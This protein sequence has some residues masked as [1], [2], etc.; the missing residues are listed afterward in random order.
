MNHRFFP[1]PCLALLLL[2][3]LPTHFGYAEGGL[4]QKSKKE[5]AK[6]ER[7]EEK[8]RERIR[9]SGIYSVSVWKYD[10]VFGRPDK[11]GT[12]LTSIRYNAAGNKVEEQTFNSTDGT[13]LSRINYRYDPDGNIVEEVKTK[14]NEKTKLVYRYD[15]T[16]NKK[17]IVSYRQDGTVDRKS[18]F[19]YDDNNNQIESRGY[20]SDG[21][22][23]SKDSFAYDSIGN[24]IEQKNSLTRFTYFYNSDGSMVEMIKS[25]RDF[26]ILDSLVYK[27]SDRLLFTYD[28]V[29]NMASLA[30]YKS[31]SSLKARSTYQYDSKGNV[32]QEADYSADGRVDYTVSYKY[33]KRQNVIE[34]SGIEKGRPFRN[35][36]KYDRR[37]NKR[38]WI[39]YD[40]V[41]EPKT[42]TKYIFEKYSTR[43]REAGAD[44]TSQPEFVQPDTADA[45]VMNED[46]FQFLGCRIIASD[47]TYLGLVWADT[48]HP[49]SIV[50]AWGQYGFE[51]SP[52]SIFNPNCPYGGLRGVFSPF[53]RSCPSPPSLYREGKFV[54]YLSDNTSFSPCVPASRLMT[55]LMQQAKAK[56]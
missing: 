41:N 10:Y 24:M 35:S 26:N 4:S 8:D 5:L 42:L 49:H 27:V 28:N 48:S 1:A 29:G 45:H 40:Q 3:F 56:E 14:G 12:Q 38:E 43:T 2:L 37:G 7:N 34:E 20:L 50:N 19:I 16:G 52:T 17:E 44:S 9:K 33:D 15:S 31:D 22:Q 55:F 51:G 6:Q 47:G 30:V 46:L 18:V 11:K 13:V 21:R 23:F 39:N 32:I 25:K 36:Y 54:S 53:N